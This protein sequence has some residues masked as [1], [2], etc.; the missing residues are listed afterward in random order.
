MKS[1]KPRS[2]KIEKAPNF[3]KTVLENISFLNLVYTTLALNIL[4]ILIVLAMRSKLP[5]QLPL[6]YGFTESEQ[7]LTSPVGLLLPGVVSFIF[8]LFNVTLSILLTDD[9]L[10][11]ILSV[12]SF[13]V[14]LLSLITV[15]KI[16]FLIGYF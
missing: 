16:I 12:A 6:F 2:F 13:T 10:K 7:Q 4:N 1:S 8:T 14:S 3:N 5:P 15:V 11:K 9:F